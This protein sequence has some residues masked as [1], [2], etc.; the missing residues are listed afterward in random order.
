MVVRLD[1]LL[2]T[3]NFPF[4][5]T[6]RLEFANHLARLESS[7]PWDFEDTAHQVAD[8]DED[9]GVRQVQ[10]RGLAFVPRATA[11]VAFEEGLRS[12]VTDVLCRT[13]KALSRYDKAFG[14][15]LYWIQAS[16]TAQS[17][18]TYVRRVRTR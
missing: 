16:F 2:F 5:G 6:P 14:R 9:E 15:A 1:P 4:V 12:A 18:G 17:D 7:L 10:S 8:G 3:S 11:V 13:F